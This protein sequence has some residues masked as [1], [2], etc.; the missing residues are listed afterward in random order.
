MDYIAFGQRIRRFRKQ[1]HLTQE[2]LAELVGISASFLGHVERGSRIASLE[3]L[4]QLCRALAVSPNELLGHELIAQYG[5][6]PEKVSISP[7]LLMEDIAALLRKQ[8]IS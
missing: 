8:T 1:K 5:E 2:A 3:T 7:E 6:L 4:M